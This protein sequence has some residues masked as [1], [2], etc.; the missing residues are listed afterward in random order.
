MFLGLGRGDSGIEIMGVD[1]A[2]G[3]TTSSPRTPIRRFV[4]VNHQ[5]AWSPDGRYIAYAS[6]RGAD[7]IVVVQSVEGN[8]LRELMP[9]PRLANSYEFRGLTWSPDGQFLVVGGTDLSGREGIYRIDAR[10][11]VT[12]PLVAPIAA[13]DRPA[14]GGFH[15]S[16]DGRRLYFSRLNGAIVE[17]DLAAGQERIIV[18]GAPVGT[19]ADTKAGRVGNISLSPDGRWIAAVL[20]FAGTGPADAVALISVATSEVKELMR[21]DRPG[22]IANDP[23]VWTSDGRSV[24]VRRRSGSDPLSVELWLQPT[25]GSAPRKLDIDVRRAEPGVKGSL[26]LSPDGGQLAYGTLERSMEVWVVTGLSSVINQR[27]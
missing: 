23:P 20:S 4:G 24:L 5:P 10:S 17:H 11:E 13:G 9:T 21:V 22:S 6:R 3:T 2:R 16:P 12:T 26:R 18:A 7:A 25:D 1:L 14:F 15:W 19:P 8:E 27:R